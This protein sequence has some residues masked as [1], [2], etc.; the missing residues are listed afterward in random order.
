M[1]EQINRFVGPISSSLQPEADSEWVRY[2]DYEKREECERQFQAKCD[3][4]L[5]VEAERDQARVQGR[6]ELRQELLDAERRH[7]GYLKRWA[8]GG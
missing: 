4:V 5:A 1:T 3:E 8:T 6:A 2:S 7:P